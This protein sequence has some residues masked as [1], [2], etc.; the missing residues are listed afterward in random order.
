MND[1]PSEIVDAGPDAVKMYER[2]L[3]EGYGHRWAEMCALK[4]PPGLK[5]TD[6]AFMQGRMNNEQ[7]DK[8]PRDHA[9]TMVQQAKQAGVSVSGK[10]YCGGIADKRGAADPLAWVSSS[11][12]VARVA[13]K[14]N[15]TVQGAVNHAG[16][17]VPRPKSKPLSERL[18]RELMQ[19]E[20]HK[21][22]TMNKGELREYVVSKYGR[23]PK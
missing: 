19:A 18:T 16:R 11:D 4:Q 9:E 14:R 3:R 7:L 8:M 1:V 17:P 2:L 10:Y 6:R 5:G 23:K 22:P 15:L 12:D 13:R 21:Q 20:K